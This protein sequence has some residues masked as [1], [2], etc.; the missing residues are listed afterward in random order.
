M[1]RGV[2]V[3]LSIGVGGLVALQAPINSLL[4]KRLGSLQ[5]A[6]VSFLVGTVALAVIALLFASG[7][8][9]GS[10]ARGAPLYYFAGGLLGAAFVA[11]SL[12]TVRVLGAGG[13]S[14]AIIAGQLAM[15]IVIDRL[16]V[17]GLPDRPLTASRLVG[18]AL[19]VA[20]VVLVVRR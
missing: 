14:A 19:L 15:S 4:G 11:S 13:V 18:V 5:A 6:T 10:G 2:A 7:P 1:P 17:L 20:G 9:S 3:M 12:V 16:G 8:S